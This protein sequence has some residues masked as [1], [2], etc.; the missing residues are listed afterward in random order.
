MY[1]KIFFFQVFFRAGVLAQ[2]ESQ[3]DEKLADLIIRFQ[4]RCRGYIAR[5]KLAKLKVS[6]RERERDKTVINYH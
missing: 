6:E 3:R 5:K 1:K 4:S 2:L